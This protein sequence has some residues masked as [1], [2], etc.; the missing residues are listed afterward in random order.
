MENVTCKLKVTRECPT[1]LKKIKAD[2]IWVKD[3]FIKYTAFY[4]YTGGFR[5][6]LLDFTVDGCELVKQT[7][8]INYNPA[9]VRVVTGIKKMFP[10]LFSGCPYKVNFIILRILGKTNFTSFSFSSKGTS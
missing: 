5:P 8:F 3:V 4:R 2:I 9:L 10:T 6:Y 7:K 1:G